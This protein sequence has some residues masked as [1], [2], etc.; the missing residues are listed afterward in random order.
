MFCDVVLMTCHSRCT[1]KSSFINL[2]MQSL[3]LRD[4]M[5]NKEKTTRVTHV[6]NTYIEYIYRCIYYIH[7]MIQISNGLV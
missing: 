7:D 5:F 6:Q 4:R 1:L 3:G 2:E